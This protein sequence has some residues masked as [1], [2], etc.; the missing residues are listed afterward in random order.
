MNRLFIKFF[1]ERII[2]MKKLLVFPF[3]YRNKTETLLAESVKGFPPGILYV[4]PHMSKVRD[5][6]MRYHAFF[7][8][9]SLLPVAQTIKTLALSLLDRHS[10]KRIISEVEKYVIILQILKKEKAV[11]HNPSQDTLRVKEKKTG[12]RF[13]HTLPGIALAIS[14]FI[15]DVKIS[16]AGRV[17]FEAIRK[18]VREYEWK[19][20]YNLSL[21]LF[22]VEVMEDYGKLLEKEKLMD[23]ED[24]YDA[25]AGYAGELKF[26]GM[27]F[28]GFSEM[29]PYQQRFISELNEKMPDVCFSFCY[30]EGVSAD[31]RELILDKSFS[32]L[33]DICRWEEKKFKT[34]EK[35]RKK[36]ECYNF[37]SQPEEVKGIAEI[38]HRH[39]AANPGIT[40]NDVMTVFPSMPSYRPVVQRIFRRYGI[41]CEILPGYSLSRNSSVST[42][43]ELFAFRDSYDWEVLMNLLMSP[44]LHNVDFEESEKFSAGSRN[45]FART[46]FLMENFL[47]AKGKNLG[48][49]K[50]ILKQTGDKPRPLKGWIE[51]V[52]AFTEKLGWDPGIPEVRFCFEK[53]MQEMKKPAVFSAEEFVNVLNRVFELVEVDEGKGSGVKVSGVQESVGLEKRL[54]IIGGATEDNIPN[55]PSLEEVFIPDTL[56]KQMGF[57]DYGLRIARERLDLYRLKNEN[58]TVLFTFP[59]KMEGKNRMKSI[60][61]FGYDESVIRDEEF[62]SQGKKFFDFEFSEGMFKKNFIVDGKL[63]ISVTQ[64]EILMKCPYRFYL[65]FVEKLK[66]YRPPEIDEAPDLWGTIIHGVTQKIFSG[67]EGRTMGPEETGRLEKNFRDEVRKGIQQ[68]FA[69]GEISGFYRDVLVLRSEE[70]CGKFASIMEGHRGYTF[71]D[72]EYEISVELPSLH[73]KGKIDRIEKAPSG[74]I[75]VI[76]IKTGTSAPPSYTEKDFFGN[77]NMQIPLYVWMY[78]KKFN[79]EEV[80]GNIWRFDFLE[81]KKTGGNEKFYYGKKLGYLDKIGD[82]LEDTAER[83]V[84]GQGNFAVENPSS[85]FYCQYK[86]VCPYEKS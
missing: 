52:E 49:M 33:R 38:I 80:V 11:N 59:S 46:G 36:I 74:E 55:A 66:P 45:N 30:D 31:A 19:F 65:Q 40:L 3:S 14:H 71:V 70:V 15:K 81:D 64:M 18:N 23:M 35:S 61:L 32:R 58:E 21:L 42:L 24:I 29:P 43:M 73:L 83:F 63:K 39:I 77:F 12:G 41:P 86:G 2:E 37:S 5:F 56:K 68:L 34:G 57:T 10:E 79:A 4:A 16:T 53:V 22:A 51:D 26:N 1:S 72:A 20:D 7:P 44:H 69:K 48:M 54:C 75:N 62:V 76:D 47:S 85:C 82:F 50:S 17:S 60:F 8:D 84:K 6:K 25:A 9:N 13:R 78:G 67:Y 28:E 27:I